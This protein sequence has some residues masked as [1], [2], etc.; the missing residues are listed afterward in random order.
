MPVSRREVDEI[1]DHSRFLLLVSQHDVTWKVDRPLSEFGQTVCMY[2][3]PPSQTG[4]ANYTDL[5]LFTDSACN[6]N[7]RSRLEPRCESFQSCIEK[8]HF[9]N[10]EGT[11]GT[12]LSGLRHRPLHTGLL[13]SDLIGATGQSLFNPSHPEMSPHA[14]AEY[15]ARHDVIT[16]EFEARLAP[17][18]RIRD[19]NLTNIL[20][21]YDPNVTKVS[22]L[23]DYH[24]C[25]FA[26]GACN[27]NNETARTPCE[28]EGMMCSRF[29]PT[30]FTTHRFKNKCQC[31][32][33][34]HYSAERDAC[35]IEDSTPEEA[36]L[37]AWYANELWEAE[38]I[39]DGELF[40]L[41]RNTEFGTLDANFYGSADE[42]TWQCTLPG[43]SSWRES[44][45]GAFGSVVR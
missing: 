17:S 27:R 11:G 24:C 20:S 37:A 10:W 6:D 3:H 39:R 12:G 14:F 38:W 35:D 43:D 21:R 8:E 29:H 25:D 2:Y 32:R 45:L 40:Q 5:S 36:A 23:D 19:A 42:G 15:S 31:E 9:L 22:E 44:M 7:S 33:G 16:A 28:G 13:M 34:M 4:C 18:T 1:Q 41:D 30:A 26:N